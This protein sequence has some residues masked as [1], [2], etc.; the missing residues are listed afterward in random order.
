MTV[1]RPRVSLSRCGFGTYRWAAAPEHVRAL[2][3]ALELGCTLVDSAPN[4]ASHGVR[5]ALGQVL[6]PHRDRVHLISKGGYTD[7]GGFSLAPAF[8][9]ERIRTEAQVVGGGYLD[10]FLLHNPEHLLESQPR[11]RVTAAVAAAF[12]ACARAYD[13]GWIH[14]FGVSSN[15][16]PDPASAM[17][18]DTLDEYAALADATGAGAAFRYVQFPF[19]VVE[20]SAAANG[21]LHRCRALGLTTIGNRPLSV[22]TATG[23]MRIA[24]APSLPAKDSERLL[25]DL[26]ALEPAMGWLVDHWAQVASSDA[27]DYV[28]ELAWSQLAPST[29]ADCPQL[30]R[31]L[32]AARR[33]ELRH[34][35]AAQT[36]ALLAATP[37]ADELG[38]RDEPIAL[39]ACRANLDHVDHVLVGLRTTADVDQLRPLF[40][41][42]PR[43]DALAPVIGLQATR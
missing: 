8:L 10:A 33:V 26:P 28:E 36:R 4:Y 14:A 41:M 42:P 30:L 37:L 40:T 43:D 2:R 24:D 22:R 19:N 6:A 1:E 27:L 32:F 35:A 3:R 38:N 18:Q 31:E 7:D 15:T 9:E 5:A 12:E 13:D 20:R 29:S 25:A 21:W 39:G 17:G 16:L 11:A 34:A 23:P